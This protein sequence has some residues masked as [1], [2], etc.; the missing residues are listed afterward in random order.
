MALWVYFN[1]ENHDK[2]F[3][4][5]GVQILKEPQTGMHYQPCR[6]SGTSLSTTKPSLDVQRVQNGQFAI[7]Y[8]P[9]KLGCSQQGWGVKILTQP[10]YIKLPQRNPEYW[11]HSCG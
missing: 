4:I 1:M 5:V 6:L 3:E 8:H 9:K 2:L 11:I 7:V 10:L